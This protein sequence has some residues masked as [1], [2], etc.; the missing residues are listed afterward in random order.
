MD[1]RQWNANMDIVINIGLGTGSR[2]RDMAMLNNILQTQMLDMQQLQAAGF[3]EEAIDM[4]PKII[5][6]QVKIAEAA[7]IKSPETFYP[8]IPTERLEQMKQQA[9]A[10]Q[11]QPSLADQAAKDKLDAEMQM[12]QADMQMRA[13]QSQADNAMKQQQMQ[14]DTQV[15]QQQLAA[16]IQLKREQ[17]QAELQ[18]KRE[19]MAAEL[20]LQRES[21]IMN[22]HV[23]ANRPIVSSDVHI[24]GQPG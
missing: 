16:E 19:Q 12:K 23:A 4:I 24:G 15:K 8:E 10:A 9:K 14:Q 3:V 21:A 5:K 2:D 13:Q 18:L 20:Q 17:L 22:A 7:G 6:T 11:G 1:P